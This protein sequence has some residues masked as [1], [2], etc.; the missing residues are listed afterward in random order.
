LSE[1]LRFLI[2]DFKLRSVAIDF[3]VELGLLGSRQSEVFL[4]VLDFTSQGSDLIV[5]LFHY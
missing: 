2:V 5:L 4:G 3:S 1:S